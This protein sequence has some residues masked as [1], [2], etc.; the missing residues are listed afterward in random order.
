ML[1]ALRTNEITLPMPVKLCAGPTIP[2]PVIEITAG[3]VPA[4][5]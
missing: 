3:D 1:F 5:I 4:G 2:G